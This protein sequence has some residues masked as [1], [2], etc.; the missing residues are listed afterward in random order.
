[1]ISMRMLKLCNDLVLPHL[2]CIF[3][4]CLESGMFPSEWKNANVVP[5]RKNGFFLFVEK[6]LKK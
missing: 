5:V 3:K 1:M 2:E 6:Y 4:S